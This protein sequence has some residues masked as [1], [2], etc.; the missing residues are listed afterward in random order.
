MRILINTE[1]GICKLLDKIS[2]DDFEYA[3]DSLCEFFLKRKYI[4]LVKKFN[5]KIELKNGNPKTS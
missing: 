3:N 1:K 2:E 4:G 5:I